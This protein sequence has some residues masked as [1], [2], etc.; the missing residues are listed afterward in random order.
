MQKTN[1]VA[2]MQLKFVLAPEAPAITHRQEQLLAQVTQ[3]GVFILD[4]DAYHGTSYVIVGDFKLTKSHKECMEATNMHGA[5]RMGFQVDCKFIG[6]PYKMAWIKLMYETLIRYISYHNKSSSDDMVA[7]YVTKLMADLHLE[8]ESYL[9]VVEMYKDNQAK[10]TL[11]N[12]LLADKLNNANND[13]IPASVDPRAL[14]SSDRGLIDSSPVSIDSEHMIKNHSNHNDTTD[15]LGCG[16]QQ[17]KTGPNPKTLATKMRKRARKLKIRTILFKKYLM[18]FATIA[19]IFA[20]IMC[21]PIQL[22]K[23]RATAVQLHSSDRGSI[24]STPVSIDFSVITNQGYQCS[25]KFC[26]DYQQAELEPAWEK[27]VW[28]TQ[29]LDCPGCP[30]YKCHELEREKLLRQ[31]RRELAAYEAANGGA[32]PIPIG[33]DRDFINHTVNSPTEYADTDI[34]FCGN[35]TQPEDITNKMFESS[36]RQYYVDCSEPITTHHNNHNS[37]TDNPEE[38]ENET[39]ADELIDDH[40][41]R[42]LNNKRRNQRSNKHK[43][44]RRDA[45]CVLKISTL[46]N[47]LDKDIIFN[48]QNLVHTQVPLYAKIDTS[49]NNS[50]KSCKNH[51][52]LTPFK[53]ANALIRCN[54]EGDLLMSSVDEHGIVESSCYSTLQ[55][56]RYRWHASKPINISDVKPYKPDFVDIKTITTVGQHQLAWIQEYDVNTVD[57]TLQQGVTTKFDVCTHN[58]IFTDGQEPMEPEIF[59]VP[60]GLQDVINREKFGMNFMNQQVTIQNESLPTPKEFLLSTISNYEE[61]CVGGNMYR[62]IHWLKNYKWYPRLTVAKYTKRV[63][64][65]T[66]ILTPIT[67]SSMGELGTIVPEVD[68]PKLFRCWHC[69]SLMCLTDRPEGDDMLQQLGGLMGLANINK[70]STHFDPKGVEPVLGWM[71]NAATSIGVQEEKP[72]FIEDGE[73]LI[74]YLKLSLKWRCSSCFN[75]CFIKPATT[76]EIF[77]QN[78]S[79]RVFGRSGLELVTRILGMDVEGGAQ[80][81]SISMNHDLRMVA[82][83]LARVHLTTVNLQHTLPTSQLSELKRSYPQFGITNGKGTGACNSALY[84]AERQLN[85]LATIRYASNGDFMKAFDN[86]TSPANLYELTQTQLADIPTGASHL[87]IS[88]PTYYRADTHIYPDKVG[89]YYE[90][91]NSIHVELDDLNLTLTCLVQDLICLTSKA[92]MLNNDVY[93]VSL[94]NR[95]ECLSLYELTKVTIEGSNLESFSYTKPEIKEFRLPML[96]LDSMASMGGMFTIVEKQAKLHV[97][98]LRAILTRNLG[99][100]EISLQTNITTALG[101]AYRKYNLPDR[102]IGNFDVTKDDVLHHAY[103]ATILMHRAI[104][105]REMMVRIFAKDYDIKQAASETIRDWTSIMAHIAMQAVGIDGIEAAASVVTQINRVATG[106]IGLE[107]GEAVF[108]EISNWCNTGAFKIETIVIPKRNSINLCTHPWTTLLRHANQCVC[109]KRLTVDS[110][111]GACDDCSPPCF[112]SHKCTHI[113]KQYDHNCEGVCQ[114]KPV[115]CTCCEIEGCY[116]RCKACDKADEN[117]EE[118]DKY[119]VRSQNLKQGLSHQSRQTDDNEEH[120]GEKKKTAGRVIPILDNQH[121]H[122]C[123]VC[124]KWFSHEHNYKNPYHTHEGACP[125][126][127]GGPGNKLEDDWQTQPSQHNLPMSP[128]AGAAWFA[129]HNVWGWNSK[130]KLALGPDYDH[131]HTCVV[132][133]KL[134]THKISEQFGTTPHPQIWN[135]CPWEHVNTETKKYSPPPEEEEEQDK[136]ADLDAEQI[137]ILSAQIIAKGH[138]EILKVLMT[139]FNHPISVPVET[140]GRLSVLPWLPRGKSVAHTQSLQVVQVYNTA[141]TVAQCGIQAITYQTGLDMDLVTNTFPNATIQTGEEIAKAGEK[142]G[143]N[144]VVMSGNVAEFYRNNLSYDFAIICHGT[145]LGK[146]AFHWYPVQVNWKTVPTC[147]VTSDVFLSVEKMGKIVTKEFPGQEYS[148]LNILER[149]TLENIIMNDEIPSNPTKAVTITKV[150]GS[151]ILKAGDGENNTLHLGNANVKLPGTLSALAELYMNPLTNAINSEPMIKP[152]N[153]G[154][155]LTTGFELEC[156]ASLVTSMRILVVSKLMPMLHESQHEKLPKLSKTSSEVIRV[157]GSHCVKLPNRLKLKDL[158]II[159]IAAGGKLVPTVVSTLKT[160][161]QDTTLVVVGNQYPPGITVEIYLD[162]ESVGSAIRNIVGLILNPPDDAMIPYALKPETCVE[163]PGGW[164]KTYTIASKLTQKSCAVCLTS[165]GIQGLKTKLKKDKSKRHL[166]DNVFSLESVLTGRFNIK[167]YSK[168]YFDEASLLRLMDVCRLLRPGMKIEYYGD[169]TQVAEIDFNKSAGQRDKSSVLRHVPN[170]HKIRTNEQ[171]RVANPACAEISKIRKGGYSYIG[172]PKTTEI[173]MDARP[174]VTPALIQELVTVHNPNVI[175][176][177]YRAQAEKLQNILNTLKLKNVSAERVHSFQGQERPNVLVLQEKPYGQAN[178]IDVDPQYVVSAATRATTRLVWVTIGDHL[179]NPQKP[180]HERVAIGAGAGIGRYVDFYEECNADQLF[181]SMAHMSSTANTRELET[182]LHNYLTQQ[183]AGDNSRSHSR[184]TI[185]THQNGVFAILNLIKNSTTKL[186]TKIDKLHANI[187]R[188][189]TELC[190]SMTNSLRRESFEHW[191][192]LLSHIDVDLQPTLEDLNCSEH[193]SR[194]DPNLFNQTKKNHEQKYGIKIDLKVHDRWDELTLKAYGMVLARFKVM[195]GLSV[196]LL[197]DNTGMITA[198]DVAILEAELKS[199]MKATINWQH[200]ILL[201]EVAKMRLIILQFCVNTL[202]M[203]GLVLPIYF[204]GEKYYMHSTTTLRLTTGFTIVDKDNNSILNISSNSINTAHRAY[205]SNDKGEQMLEKLMDTGNVEDW[206]N[207]IGLFT[208]HDF[209]LI[210]TTLMVNDWLANNFSKYMMIL[211][212]LGFNSWADVYNNSYEKLKERIEL[213]HPNMKVHTL[214]TNTNTLVNTVI[215]TV[216]NPSGYKFAAYVVGSELKFVPANY[217]QVMHPCYTRVNLLDDVLRGIEGSFSYKIGTMIAKLTNPRAFSIPN[218]VQDIT[219]HCEQN[220]EV[221]VMVKNWVGKMQSRA[222]R[223]EAKPSMIPINANHQ[224]ARSMNQSAEIGITTDTFDLQENVWLHINAIAHNLQYNLHNADVFTSCTN[225]GVSLSQFNTRYSPHK[226]SKNSKTYANL[227]TKINNQT[228]QRLQLSKAFLHKD[229]ADRVDLSDMQRAV[230]SQKEGY[231]PLC[232]TMPLLSPYHKTALIMPDSLDTDP[233]EIIQDIRAETLLVVIPKLNNPKNKTLDTAT[234]T[235]ISMGVSGATFKVDKKWVEF[236]EKGV[237][238]QKQLQTKYEGL[239]LVARHSIDQFVVYEVQYYTGPELIHLSTSCLERGDRIELELPIINLD[240]LG[241]IENKLQPIMVHKFSVDKRLVRSLELRMLREDMDFQKLLNATRSLMNMTEYTTTAYYDTFKLGVDEAL[242]TATFIWMVNY[243]DY[244]GVRRACNMLVASNID[245]ENYGLLAPTMSHMKAIGLGS[246]ARMMEVAGFTLTP[247][248]LTQLITKLSKEK[249]LIEAGNKLKQIRM[250]YRDFNRKK[251]T[252]FGNVELS[253]SYVTHVDLRKNLPRDIFHSHL[254]NITQYWSVYQGN[255]NYQTV[256]ATGGKGRHSEVDDSLIKQV[257][258]LPQFTMEQNEQLEAAIMGTDLT[259]AWLYNHLNEEYD[260]AVATKRINALLQAMRTQNVKLMQLRILKANCQALVKDTT[261]LLMTTGVESTLNAEIEQLV[262][263]CKEVQQ[264]PNWPIMDYDTRLYDNLNQRLKIDY[265]KLDSAAITEHLSA[266]S[267]DLIKLGYVIKSRIPDGVKDL[268]ITLVVLG[269][270]GDL[271]PSLAAAAALLLQGCKLNIVC[272]QEMANNFPSTENCKIV[273]GQWSIQKSLDSYFKAL[274]TWDITAALSN[275]SQMNWIQGVD[276]SQLL[277]T[278]LVISTPIAPQGAFVATWLKV[279]IIHLS[280]MPFSCVDEENSSKSTR[281]LLTITDKMVL[282][283]NRH[284]LERDGENLSVGFDAVLQRKIPIIYQLEKS[285][286]MAMNPINDHEFIGS[287]G[288]NR[289]EEVR[290]I[291]NKINDMALITYGSMTPVDLADRIMRRV[292]NAQELGYRT[293]IVV[294]NSINVKV[295]LDA[296]LMSTE[297]DTSLSAIGVGHSYTTAT[298]TVHLTPYLNYAGTLGKN[299]FMFHHGGAGTTAAAVIAKTPMAIDPVAFDQSFWADRMAKLGKAVIVGKNQTVTTAMLQELRENL[300]TTPELEFETARVD[301]LCKAICRFYKAQT[302]QNLTFV[303]TSDDDIFR[304]PSGSGIKPWCPTIPLQL[305]LPGQMLSLDVTSSEHPL[306]NWQRELTAGEIDSLEYWDPQLDGTQLEAGPCVYYSICHVMNLDPLNK[307]NA[308][309]LTADALNISESISEGITSLTAAKIVIALG[310]NCVILY[311]NMATLYQHHPGRRTVALHFTEDHCS[312]IMTNITFTLANELRPTVF[313]RPMQ[314]EISTIQEPNDEGRVVSVLEKW[315]LYSDGRPTVASSTTAQA[316][317]KEILNNNTSKL[318]SGL[319]RECARTMR[320]YDHRISRDLQLGRQQTDNWLTVATV[321]QYQNVTKLA[322]IDDSSGLIFGQ[323]YGALTAAGAVVPVCAISKDVIITGTLE[324]ND[325]IVGCFIYLRL[326]LLWN[327]SSKPRAELDGTNMESLQYM[328]SIGEL[329]RVYPLD[330]INSR[331]VKVHNYDAMQHHLY[332]SIEV[333]QNGIADYGTNDNLTQDYNHLFDLTRSDH[334]R[335]GLCEGK[336]A[337]VIHKGENRYMTALLKKAGKI[338]II[339]RTQYLR[340]V[341]DLFMATMTELDNDKNITWKGMHKLHL[342]TKTGEEWFNL[343]PTTFVTTGPDRLYRLE[344]ADLTGLFDEEDPTMFPETL[345]D[346]G[347]YVLREPATTHPLQ[348]QLPV[349]RLDKYWSSIPDANLTKAITNLHDKIGGVTQLEYDVIKKANTVAAGLEAWFLVATGLKQQISEHVDGHDR[350]YSIL[351]DETKMITWDEITLYCEGVEIAVQAAVKPDNMDPYISIGSTHLHLCENANLNAMIVGRLSSMDPKSARVWL[352]DELL[353]EVWPH[354]LKSGKYVGKDGELHDPST[355]MEDLCKE[356]RG[357]SFIQNLSLVEILDIIPT[358]DS[359]TKLVKSASKSSTYPSLGYNT[360]TTRVITITVNEPTKNIWDVHEPRTDSTGLYRPKETNEMRN[361]THKGLHNLDYD[362]ILS[363]DDKDLTYWAN[364]VQVIENAADNLETNQIRICANAEFDYD[365]DGLGVNLIYDAVLQRLGWLNIV[366]KCVSGINQEMRFTRLIG[367]IFGAGKYY[368][369]I[370]GGTIKSVNERTL[371]FGPGK[372]Q[373]EYK[374]TVYC[375][376]TASNCPVN[377]NCSKACGGILAPA[378]LEWA[379]ILNRCCAIYYGAD[380]KLL[381][382]Y[383]YI[384]ADCT[385]HD[386]PTRADPCIL[387]APTVESVMPSR[388]GLWFY[389][390][391]TM[392]YKTN[393]T[394]PKGAN[395]Y[396]F[397][398]AMGISELGGAQPK[399]GKGSSAWAAQITTQWL[400]RKTSTWLNGTNIQTIENQWKELMIKAGIDGPVN[401]T[402]FSGLSLEMKNTLLDKF[403]R[404]KVLSIQEDRPMGEVLKQGE[405]L[406]YNP[407]TLVRTARAK[408]MKPSTNQDRVQWFE[409]D[410][411]Y[412]EKPAKI[413]GN[414]KDDF[415]LSFAQQEGGDGNWKTRKAAIIMP[416][417]TGK[418]HLASLYPSVFIDHDAIEAGWPKNKIREV[419]ELVK[420]GEWELLNALHRSVKVPEGKILLTWSSGSVPA[421]VDILGCIMTTRINE[422]IGEPRRTYALGNRLELSLDR[423]LRIKYV[424][425]NQAVTEAAMALVSEWKQQNIYRVDFPTKS[426]EDL[427]F[428]QA[429]DVQHLNTC[430]STTVDHRPWL[431]FIPNQD[432]S[433]DPLQQSDAEPIPLAVLNFWEDK[434]QVELVRVFAPTNKP[435]LKNPKSSEVPDTIVNTNKITLV[436]F[437]LRSRPVLTKMIFGEL[438]ATSIR[439]EDQVVFRR[440]KLDPITELTEFKKTYFKSEA[441]HILSALPEITVD[442]KSVKEWLAMR[443]GNKAIDKEIDA[444]EKEGLLNHPIPSLNVHQKMEALLKTK[445]INMLREQQVRIIV[446]QQKGI[447]ALFSQ[448]FLEAKR[449]LKSLLKPQFL[450]ADGLRP[451]ELSARFRNV[452]DPNQ[453]ITL[454]ENDL[455]KQDKQT[456][457]DTLA[458]EFAVYNYLKVQPWIL[459]LWRTAH[460]LWRYKGTFVRGTSDGMRQTGQ[461]TTALGNVLVNLF[462]HRRLVQELGENMAFFAV[463]GDDGIMLVKRDIDIGK[464]K[465]NS[466]AYWNMLVKT[467]QDRTVGKFLQMIV[468]RNSDGAFQAGP[469]IIRLKNRFEVTNGVSQNPEE[470]IKER[471]L[472]YN[473]MLGD[474]KTGRQVNRHYGEVLTLPNYYEEQSVISAT[475]KYYKIDEEEVRNDLSGLSEMLR[476]PQIHQKE[477]EH[478]TCSFGTRRTGQVG[479]LGVKRHMHDLPPRGYSNTS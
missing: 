51:L 255:S 272:P 285:L 462:V 189:I 401:Y 316:M 105:S 318:E 176:C 363:K 199:T 25:D 213:E 334:M 270:M 437:P 470:V 427:V 292:N 212:K 283:L 388:N 296:N 351:E 280:P 415:Q 294:A 48:G 377:L 257:L 313:D 304:N 265:M 323:I 149:L 403:T 205:N 86:I 96:K 55:P 293:I 104:R 303:H 372:D 162:S 244:E 69:A 274:E 346:N 387:W 461:V 339:N 196:Q 477:W 349:E 446:W 163:A 335:K 7:A 459:Q 332:H 416:V 146:Q 431:P 9:S 45:A 113:C 38:P 232:S 366:V 68:N 44:K 411:E 77:R 132:C 479:F 275:E 277:G 452:S 422:T 41:T 164:G 192:E 289:I 288:D 240:I 281:M 315:T 371:K 308:V 425:N 188:K 478:F 67:Y 157:A 145:V 357:K 465:A 122:T 392:V 383:A 10:Y 52:S 101:F 59:A 200:A 365:G 438:N 29:Y 406:I 60:A 251:R 125:W 271:R 112:V 378:K 89:I 92:I 262:L 379:G 190:S 455:E 83:N 310:L 336:L 467:S 474:T 237:L 179:Q 222:L 407:M 64:S 178:F 169:M 436:P 81:R 185:K 158:D 203:G 395:P 26:C 15:K 177:F 382:R 342:Q 295:K 398:A 12:Q 375:H 2:G 464:F 155:G 160:R 17:T 22:V 126:H 46:A 353:V 226:L 168:I 186:K 5:Y 297:L 218:L 174:K 468:C 230:T 95:G 412:H 39:S 28:P 311:R 264:S 235:V 248:Q 443:T 239:L 36:L 27:P 56:E 445:P 143:I 268:T 14:D 463:L 439:M 6:C 13:S 360:I 187:R 451:D 40:I 442:W 151:Y 131:I 228:M 66:E 224:L 402:S 82:L 209:K 109:C 221:G 389:R 102:T 204:Q 139:E 282:Q 115:K 23:L 410:P 331:K 97:G 43:K 11:N 434:D 418:T 391:G 127:A 208:S 210:Y 266:I 170:E 306:G 180:L 245:D 286:S 368:Y 42:I 129:K 193:L 324:D 24:D 175:L 385:G 184:T 217:M 259:P 124:G 110:E 71:Q 154:S 290:P 31:Y 134:Y 269:S 364:I 312:V 93:L 75:P 333:L 50:Y 302:N 319:A 417:G 454:V 369:T 99:N 76:L 475:A 246:L 32:D 202:A 91:N 448:V 420:N 219:E 173:H 58:K 471:C 328:K 20:Q 287:W 291:A 123:H 70:P 117:D 397:A 373:N 400:T 47:I 225:V 159:Y 138:H 247:T 54:L 16:H 214:K 72:R 148:N 229:D 340:N 338:T 18:V 19:L 457:K 260:Y 358:M 263:L 90:N 103:V 347:F 361:V 314:L 4:T 166:T 426:I 142:L 413:R 165:G 182:N 35:M 215:A 201:P 322:P 390:A 94:L 354:Q 198:R 453:H 374:S 128:T 381:A 74:D 197:E 429:H 409:D 137:S 423:T 252:M 100:T 370:I 133:G 153:F 119:I 73:N 279:P 236:V 258:N 1:M 305:G 61:D 376:S 118:L 78:H 220:D 325:Y 343:F 34:D 63:Y 473:M 352:I 466:K 405:V 444:I 408:G 329:V 30:L 234:Q 276:Y 469:D 345:I 261:A 88:A 211:T 394:L 307:T 206:F 79:E 301:A 249:S 472:S 233:L 108:N 194:V 424:P 428:A 476:K 278:D 356:N 396:H 135:E 84:F 253:R 53:G 320:S 140:Q 172:E 181:S 111:G 171:R 300:D 341:S 350:T 242:D 195:A 161:I 243:S 227:Y 106:T 348:E 231:G 267:H 80:W 49:G 152:L 456:D 367:Y 441:D 167:N 421:G 362:T 191:N 432:S 156:E 380:E 241:I 330:E 337:F 3:P 393:A 207:D 317:I 150:E 298:S 223:D 216:E 273:A 121:A 87:Y 107:T 57:V 449:R 21:G 430:C 147:M 130:W 8:N 435:V 414:Q 419:E 355:M 85:E 256:P 327:R 399:N 458:C 37:T 299:C 344:Q 144:L 326:R 136:P 254:S 447:T 238:N 62:K 321:I 433:E 284:H 250:T 120:S 116:T 404:A 460:E 309:R 440:V 183:S 33:G 450:Y 359:N 98:L 141:M 386:V 65:T 114:H 384:M